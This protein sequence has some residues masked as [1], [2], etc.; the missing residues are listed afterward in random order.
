MDKKTTT[1][2]FKKTAMILIQ[3]NGFKKAATILNVTINGQKATF[4]M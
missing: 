1:V 2:I 3:P 4:V